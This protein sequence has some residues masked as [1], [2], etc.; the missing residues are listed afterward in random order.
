MLLYMCLG[1]GRGLVFSMERLHKKQHTTPD[2]RPAGAARS[3]ACA[4]R[5]AAHASHTARRTT[6][7]ARQHPQQAALPTQPQAVHASPGVRAARR[8]ALGPYLQQPLLR[9]PP[10]PP[11]SGLRCCCCC[12][13]WTL[14]V[15]RSLLVPLV[16]MAKPSGW[17][18]AGRS[19]YCP[20]RLAGQ[21]AQQGHQQG[22]EQASKERRQ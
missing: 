4:C 2:S 5:Q 1:G 21:Q 11:C 13:S 8:P 12:R 9:C 17:C 6:G 3:T 20:P 22:W 15:L 16:M 10:R 18:R 7:C 19:S 14:P